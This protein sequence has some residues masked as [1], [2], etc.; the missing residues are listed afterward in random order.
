MF[1]PPSSYQWYHNVISD[2]QLLEVEGWYRHLLMIYEQGINVHLW[3]FDFILDNSKVLPTVIQGQCKAP[4]QLGES[5]NRFCSINS[6]AVSIFGPFIVS[7]LGWVAWAMTPGARLSYTVFRYCLLAG[8][9]EGNVHVHMF[10]PPPPSIHLSFIDFE[11]KTR[12]S[13][14]NRPKQM[15][16]QTSTH[17]LKN[18][19]SGAKWDPEPPGYELI[20][21]KRLNLE[22]NSRF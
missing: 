16:N 10:C 4:C 8:T 9:S 15:W 17:I 13:N 22:K 20:L 12:V 14:W 19:E 6:F 1:I 11:T 3:S 5:L 7:Q 2:W 21:T 18:M